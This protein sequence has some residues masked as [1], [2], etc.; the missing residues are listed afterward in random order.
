M[1]CPRSS[2]ACRTTATSITRRTPSHVTSS[3]NPS[4]QLKKATTTQPTTHPTTTVPGTT[5]TTTSKPTATS[6]KP[7][8]K[9]MESFIRSYVAAVST[10]PDQAWPMLTPKFQR[11]SGGLAKYRKFWGGV[12]NGRVLQITADPHSL[13]VSYRVR[14]DNFGSG[15]RPTVLNL[16]YRD[17]HYLIDGESTQGFKP[18]G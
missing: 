9:G 3:S 13:V 4:H 2:V 8:A 10:D 18:A 16:V 11:E 17:G 12:G 1:V 7:T 5:T 14:F 6:T 15:K